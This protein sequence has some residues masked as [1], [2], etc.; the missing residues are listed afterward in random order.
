MAPWPI[1]T[2]Y[3][4]N[5]SHLSECLLVYPP[6]IARQLLDKNVTAAT[7]THGTIEELT[8]LYN[9]YVLH[10]VVCRIY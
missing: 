8:S 2:K 4:L 10:P 1:S 9:L 3:F 6:L 7:N 5:S